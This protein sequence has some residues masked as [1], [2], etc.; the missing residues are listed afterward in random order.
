M[1]WKARGDGQRRDA[2][3][4]DTPSHLTSVGSLLIFADFKTQLTHHAAKATFIGMIFNTV[5]M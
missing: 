4:G 2:I 3:L 5:R 1:P